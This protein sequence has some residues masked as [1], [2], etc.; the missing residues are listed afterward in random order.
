MRSAVEK[1]ACLIWSSLIAV[2]A[3]CANFVVDV[4][5][6]RTLLK[7]FWDTSGALLGHFWDTYITFLGHLWDTS[8]TLLM[9]HFW[10]DT[11]EGTF[12]SEF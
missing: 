10:W 1:M 3:A 7:H 6:L 9:G 12:L 11:F 4:L 8:V 5:I 2:V